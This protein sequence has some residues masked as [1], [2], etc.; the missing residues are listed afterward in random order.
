MGI[1]TLDWEGLVSARPLETA[2]FSMT[3]AELRDAVSDAFYMMRHVGSLCD[4]YQQVH[5]HYQELL[6]IQ[7][8]RAALIRIAN[9]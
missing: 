8:K 3:N 7:Q 4:S 5:K 6:V 2:E 9:E 1:S